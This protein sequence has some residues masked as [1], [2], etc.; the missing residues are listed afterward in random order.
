MNT[1]TQISRVCERRATLLS[2]V[3]TNVF[4]C[5][6]LFGIVSFLAI[7]FMPFSLLNLFRYPCL[8][9][10]LGISLYIESKHM[11]SFSNPI[12]SFN[13]FSLLML[14]SAVNGLLF[15]PLIQLVGSTNLAIA[16]VSTFALLL[17]SVWVSRNF[18]IDSRDL[19]FISISLF[20]V[21]GL[22]IL[23][24]FLRLSM[25]E[26]LIC[27]LGLISSFGCCAYEIY[28]LE[29]SNFRGNLDNSS[30]VIA[31]RVFA[32]ML[33]MFLYIIRFLYFFNSKD[34]N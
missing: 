33:S 30:S 18:E 32:S 10:S 19:R 15:A 16:S 14:Y 17:T 28:Q 3:Y 7:N 2:K 1:I 9:A 4:F 11:I 25:I 13:A 34:K 6:S 31:L 20:T 8:F 22:S 29:N 27:V 23:N 26:F 24:M 5:L 21:L 12:S